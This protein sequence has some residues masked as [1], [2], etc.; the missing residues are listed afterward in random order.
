MKNQ[1][2]SFYTSIYGQNILNKYDHIWAQNMNHELVMLSVLFLEH[3]L[4]FNLILVSD[5]KI[6]QYT[7]SEVDSYTESQL[8]NQRP[9]ILYKYPGSTKSYESDTSA[10]PSL[11][12]DTVRDR[13]LPE[14]GNVETI[15]T[16]S[17]KT[18]ILPFQTRNTDANESY[19][20]DITKPDV[21]PPIKPDIISHITSHITHLPSIPTLDGPPDLLDK[22]TSLDYDVNLSTGTIHTIHHPDVL[23]NPDEEKECMGKTSFE[24]TLNE[25]NAHWNSDNSVAPEHLPYLNPDLDVT[26]GLGPDHMFRTDTDTTYTSNDYVTASESIPPPSLTNTTDNLSANTDID[27]HR[28][29]P[30]PGPKFAE[31]NDIDTSS[32]LSLVEFSEPVETDYSMI[33]DQ[34]TPQELF[35]QQELNKQHKQQQVSENIPTHSDRNVS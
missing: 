26:H 5:N 13:Y 23:N 31:E 15:N 2:V 3:N 20:G 34:N 6:P 10:C 33:V 14:E 16:V 22:L 25:S 19:N 35:D 29:S 17:I 24:N 9:Q 18:P 7:A 30:L 32:P 4:L 11:V 1:T 12:T 21:I 27:Y 8:E 28:F